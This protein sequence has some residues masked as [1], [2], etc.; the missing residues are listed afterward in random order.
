MEIPFARALGINV[1]SVL[2]DYFNEI[3]NLG[4]VDLRNIDWPDLEEKVQE[5]YEVLTG[6]G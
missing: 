6:G 2:R 5:Q 1:V 3:S 4:V